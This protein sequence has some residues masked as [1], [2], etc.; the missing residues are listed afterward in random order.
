MHRGATTLLPLHREPSRGMTIGASP[1]RRECDRIMCLG[2][3]RSNLLSDGSLVRI[4]HGPPHFNL[5]ISGRRRL[6][7]APRS[8]GIR[9]P[10]APDDIADLPPLVVEVFAALD[11]MGGKGVPEGVNP[12]AFRDPGS[13]LAW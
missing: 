4:Q 13:G 6:S 5:A 2:L 1:I 9:R 10:V 11:G 3:R 7:S 12:A 8:T